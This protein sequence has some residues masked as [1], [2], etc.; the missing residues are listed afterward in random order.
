MQVSLAL[1][2]IGMVKESSM[3]Y[4]IFAGGFVAGLAVGYVITCVLIMR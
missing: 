3:S 1:S 4:A 2:N